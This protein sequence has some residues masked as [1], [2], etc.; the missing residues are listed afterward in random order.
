MVL[1]RLILFHFNPRLV[2]FGGVRE[3]LYPQNRDIGR[4]NGVVINKITTFAKLMLTISSMQL[5]KLIHAASLV[6]LILAVNT[7]WAACDLP[8]TTYTSTKF[9]SQLSNREIIV[10]SLC[11][12]VYLIE[13][14]T[15][16]II[17]KQH[18]T[19]NF[20]SSPV[21]VGNYIVVGSCG[22]ENHKFRIR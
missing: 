9:T 1:P 7:A 5:K 19:N 10:G 3:P 13:A 4:K 14:L 22:R 21:I 18:L 16:H 15:D 2:L 11:G 20:E 17:F 6:L 8:N 12:N